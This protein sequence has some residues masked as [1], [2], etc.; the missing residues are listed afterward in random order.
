VGGHKWFA[1]K[2]FHSASGEYCWC[3]PF[4]AM[5][6]QAVEVTLD[7]GNRVSLAELAG[8]GVST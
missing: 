1:T 5:L 3:I 4:T 7:A 6:G 8:R 2:A